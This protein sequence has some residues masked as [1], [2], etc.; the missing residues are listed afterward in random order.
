VDARLG[1]AVAETVVVDNASTDGSP[2][3]LAR[4]FP[5]V[6][7]LRQSANLGFAA[8][9]N[10]ALRWVAAEGIE[11]RFVLFLNPDTELLDGPWPE[12]LS[13]LDRPS[14]VVAWTPALIAPDGGFDPGVGGRRPSLRSL[15]VHF[16]GLSHLPFCHDRGV[17]LNQ[18]APF[19]R[20]R[21][22]ALD[23]L[24]G[25]ALLVRGEAIA[26]VHGFPEDFFMYGEDMLLGER[27][28]ARGRLLYLPVLRVLHDRE[29]S[30]RGGERS[31]RS[32]FALLQRGGAGPR[33]L[34]WARRIAVLGLGARRWA[35]RLAAPLS[36]ACQRRE[37]I[38]ATQLAA[39]R[40]LASPSDPA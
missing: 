24:S 12:V 14:D 11:P 8:G 20:Q 15:A 18:A 16:L 22:V 4:E 10:V 35:Y 25:T 2:E 23:W 17:F 34:A 32:L 36:P 3:R 27:L 9:N 37:V 1:T 38:V 26:S 40:R 19:R 5:H 30:E 33:R 21:R 28:W 6:P 13:E 29:Y 39:L 7:L 31:Y